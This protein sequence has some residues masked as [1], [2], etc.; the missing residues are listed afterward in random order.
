M[1]TKIICTL[2]PTSQTEDVLKRMADAGMSV[3]RFN[4]SHG[5][6][7][8]HLRLMEM[9]RKI[10]KK[11]GLEIKLL[12]DLEGYRI[13]IGAF[14]RHKPIP[15]KNGQTVFLTA[16]PVPGEGNIIPFDFD[17]SLEAFKD[18]EHIFIDDGTICL[19]I[20]RILKDRIQA[21]VLVGGDINEHKGINVPG[22][23]FR[24]EGLTDKD[25][26]DVLLGIDQKVDFIAQSFVRKADDML[27]LKE[28]VKDKHPKCK[29]IAKIENEEG[30]DNIDEIID[31][32][33]GIMVARGDLGVSMPIYEVPVFQKMII[34][35]CNRKKKIDITATQMLENMVNHIRPTRAE[36]SDI[37]NAVL[38]RSDYIMLSGETAK[39]KY[40]VEAVEMMKNVIKFTEESSIFKKKVSSKGIKNER[41]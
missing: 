5:K 13:R 24:I 11:H 33:D 2:G 28:A 40:P 10:N 39:G 19:K 30:L 1:R 21:K 20:I 37:A 8:D 35:K 38:D 16:K 29:F 7:A 17:G 22:I 32:S 12:Q 18:L 41:S 4:F 31:V 23:R 27:A 14:K 26:K 9:V 34:R 3:A 36:V 6:H 15:V 25:K